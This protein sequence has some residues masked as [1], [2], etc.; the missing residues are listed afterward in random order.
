MFFFT[1]GLCCII[2][3]EKHRKEL[4]LSISL[5]AFIITFFIALSNFVLENSSIEGLNRT[6]EGF[7]SLVNSDKG[8][9]NSTF[10]LSIYLLDQYFDTGGVFG[11]GYAERGDFAY[12]TFGVV[13]LNNFVADAR[14]AYLLVEYGLLGF[15]LYMITFYSFFSDMKTRKDFTN[16]RTKLFVCY[17]Y[18]F[19]LSLTE[20]GFFDRIFLPY[21]F[22]FA[23]TCLRTTTKFENNEISI[24]NSCSYGFR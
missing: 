10:D 21:M 4:L 22:I 12:G 17:C 16:C 23:F 2:N 9:T 1:Y 15:S 24:P 20:A 11:N 18:Y 13:S 6:M 14:I 8:S 3:W 7:L 19:V 5:F